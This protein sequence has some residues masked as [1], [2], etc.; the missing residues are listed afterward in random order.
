MSKLSFISDAAL[1]NRRGCGP[2]EPRDS[3]PVADQHLAPECAEEDDALHDTYEALREVDP[4]QREARVLEPAQEH[5]DETD[6][7]SVV[8]GESGNDDPCV[9][10]GGSLETDRIERMREVADLAGTSDPGERPRDSHH[11]EDLAARPDSR[12][13]R[14]TL[15]VGDHAHLETEARAGVQRRDAYGDREPEDETQ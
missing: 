6:G 13:A 3:Q 10:E 14:G 15:R 5:R 11:R 7:Q 9:A 12:G 4:L 8:A 2:R 1:R